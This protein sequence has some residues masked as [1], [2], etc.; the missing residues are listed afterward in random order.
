MT[1][2]FSFVPSTERKIKSLFSFFVPSSRKKEERRRMESWTDFLLIREKERKKIRKKE[3]KIPPY[4]LLV[5]DIDR[6]GIFSIFLNGEYTASAKRNII[7]ACD[8]SMAIIP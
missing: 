8:S 2:F 7:V 3:E 6:D 5:F 4:I 1:L